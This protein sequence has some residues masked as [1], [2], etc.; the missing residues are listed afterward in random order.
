MNSQANMSPQD[1]P[2]DGELQI[3]GIT[4]SG[5]DGSVPSEAIV[6]EGTSSRAEGIRA[7]K[8]YLSRLLGEENSDWHLRRQSLL[9][10]DEQ[11]IDKLTVETPSN[12][13]EAFYFEVSG[14]FRAEE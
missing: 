9:A 11:V 6:I 12:E 3:D 10:S 2:E 4:Y 8:R 14:F 13:R 7:E 1:I 5:G